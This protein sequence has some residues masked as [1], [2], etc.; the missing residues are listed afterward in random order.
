MVWNLKR[1]LPAAE[2]ATIND[3]QG[4]VV[5][6]NAALESARAEQAAASRDTGSLASIQQVLRTALGGDLTVRMNTSN[7]RA[8]HLEVAQDLNSLLAMFAESIDSIQ[9][10]ASSAT[11]GNLNSRIDTR[12]RSGD[13]RRATE[14]VNHLLESVAEI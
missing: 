7:L 10:A 2:A 8:E 14:S 13:V 1:K 12:N 4:Q 3:L 5:S 6:L 11:D 9:K